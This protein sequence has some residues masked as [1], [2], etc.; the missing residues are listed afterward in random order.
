MAAL[1][2]ALLVAGMLVG[3][4]AASPTTL[5]APASD[6]PAVVS[7]PFWSGPVS[8]LAGADRYATAAAISRATFPS[9]PVPVA[10]VATGRGFPDA[11]AGGPAAAVE[12][13]PIL[14]TRPDRLPDVVR[15][16]LTRLR[17]GSIRVLGGPAAVSDAVV[18]ALRSYTSGPV[19]RL[20]G[21]DRYATAA[22]IVENVFGA[23]RGPVFVASGGNFPDALAGGAAAA[24]KRAPLAL[25]TIDDVPGSI[26]AALGKLTPTSFVLLG[27]PGVLGA[28]VVGELQA[29]YPGVPIER[30]SGPDRYATSAAISAKAFPTGADTVFVATGTD[31][32]DAL[33][34]VPAAGLADAP[35]LLATKGCLPP[36]TFVE[37]QRL[38]PTS[39]V[40]LGGSSVVDG[41]APTTVCGPP[42]QPA[43]SVDCLDFPNRSLAQA[44][45]DHYLPWF[46]DIA[47]IDDDGD[48]QACESL[49]PGIVPG[50]VDRTSIQLRATY[51]VKATLGFDSRALGTDTTITAR[52]DSGAGIDRVELNTIAA[53]LGAMRGLAAWVDGRSVRPSVTDQTIVVPLGGVLP[54]GGTTTIRVV[55]RAT[56]RSGVSG[57]DWL[58]T[59]ANGIVDLY[60]W[61]P[62]V[63]L[64]RP[65]D[66]PNHGDPFVTPVSPLV[67]VSLT[68]DRAL[69]VAQAG[70][71][72][73]VSGLTQVFE[74]RDVRDFVLT[75]APDFRT[76]S[77]TVNG[78]LVQAFVRPGVS[79]SARVE[80]AA[81]A[82]ARMT[83][84]LGS[85]PTT[86][87]AVA[88]SAGGY[89]MEGP[90][91][92]WIPGSVSSS[93]L[94]YLVTHETAHQWFY[95]AVGN[96]QANHPFV[97]E[98]AT[99]F[100]A[101]HV[102]GMRRASQCSAGRLDLS[103][104]G[105]TA[106][107]YYERIYVQ[108]GNLI[109]DLRRRMGDTA[110]WRAMRAYVAANRLGIA[111]RR[112]LPD[113]LDAGT[114]LD[115]RPY[116]A[117][118][119]PAWY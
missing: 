34:G 95:A 109:D 11:L 7:P 59:R 86:Y 30:W 79:S 38:D 77:R 113:T 107:C 98:A 32:P 63:S 105:Y 19:A 9:P 24:A 1:T 94:P 28:R 90:G 110:F 4:A 49:P 88:Q 27:G 26:M 70:R 53:R 87:L 14:L 40:L 100:L 96:D 39:V 50:S 76:G 60:R 102:L 33:A 37:L 2:A 89:G 52:N 84:K 65:F 73:S 5:L 47:G 41:T 91:I 45:Y 103:I 61:I 62:W 22:R 93:S 92:I 43:G 57:S 66:R 80:A 112:S 31:F 6:A 108:G 75:A 54:A 42:P 72:V 56:L 82:V 55:F 29:R 97:D 51:D 13:G 67:R 83:A 48:G 101:R 25:A 20:A 15:A 106:A 21:V 118:R 85:F 115:L 44:W 117:P 16:E 71:R 68:T 119:F 10:Y 46:G 64:R 36:A 23:Y 111:G 58:F 18:A 35:L 81:T 69:V 78:V 114:P 116:I 12:G 74:A 8:R 3:P 104:Y 99:D 17:P